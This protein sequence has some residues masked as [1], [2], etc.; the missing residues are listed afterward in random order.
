M[1]QHPDTGSG[2]LIYM[3]GEVFII[4]RVAVLKID[5]R[6]KWVDPDTKNARAGCISQSCRA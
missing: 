1:I 3:A 5:L 6:K 4:Q 2:T